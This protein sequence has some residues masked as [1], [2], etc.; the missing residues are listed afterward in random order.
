MSPDSG[1]PLTRPVD[2]SKLAHDGK[3]E[4]LNANVSPSGSLAVGTN[5]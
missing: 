5:E 3:A 4:T 1:V 2:V